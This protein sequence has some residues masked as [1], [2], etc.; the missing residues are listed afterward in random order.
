[1]RTVSGLIKEIIISY[2]PTMVWAGLTTAKVW[3]INLLSF[4]SKGTYLGTKLVGQANST[5]QPVEVDPD[6]ILE[7]KEKTVS[8]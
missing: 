5:G 2:L 7:A 6:A 4:I 1:M 8:K 3:I